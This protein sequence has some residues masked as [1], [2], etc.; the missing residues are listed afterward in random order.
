M[1][2]RA[3]G[4]KKLREKVVESYFRGVHEQNR[5]QI[6]ACFHPDGTKITDVCALSSGTRIATPFELGERCMEFLAAHPDC[7]VKFHYP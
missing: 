2:L 1:R 5:E 4:G 7:Q 6:A 3:G